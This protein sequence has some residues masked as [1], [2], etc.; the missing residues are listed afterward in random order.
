MKEWLRFLIPLLAT[1]AL[2]TGI[3]SFLVSKTSQSWFERDVALRS[4]LAVNS[5]RAS[6][7]RAWNLHDSG[8]LR[9]QLEEITRDTR[10]AGAGVCAPGGSVAAMA[11]HSG[12]GI[13]C[14]R[15]LALRPA[16]NDQ[17][18]HGAYPG[19]ENEHFSAVPV[20][21]GGIEVCVVVIIHDMTYAERRAALT[22]QFTFFAL[23]ALAITSSA[24]TILFLR[25]VRR[26]WDTQIRR[27]LRGEGARPEFQ[28]LRHD[29]QELARQLSAEFESSEHWNAERLRSV[30]HR[31]LH[32][33]QIIVLANREP[34]I[35]ERR[36]DGEIELVHPASGVVTALEPVMRACSGVWIAHGAGSADREMSDKNGRLQVPPGE[37]LYSLRRVWL[38]QEEERG[39]YYGFA[40]E[41]LWP[42]CHLAHARPMFRATDFRHYSRINARFAAAA[43]QEGKVRDPI[44]W[45]QDYHF[46]LAP[47]LV[48][49]KLPAATIL[50]FWH[51][52]WPNAER[53]GICPWHKELIAGLLGS[54]ILGFHTQLHCNNFLSAIDRFLETR[55]DR[56]RQSV[57][58]Q[59]H[60]TIVRPYP[61]S[62]EWPN[63]WAVA[64]PAVSECRHALITECDLKQDAVIGLGVDRLDYT[65]G[66]AERFLA[67]ERALERFPELR[68]RFSFVQLAAPSRTEIERYRELSSQIEQIVERINAR[69]GRGTYRPI[70]YHRAHH[71]PPKVF[72]FYRACDFCY[73][74]SLHDGMNLVA[75]EFVAARDDERGVLILSNFAG[76]SRELSSALIVNPYD[77][78]EASSAFATAV[79]MSSEEQ[80]ERMRAMRQTVAKFNVYRWA[81]RMMMDTAG[82]RQHTRLLSRYG[83]RD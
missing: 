75:K 45:I 4:E 12:L 2:L 63:S 28:P 48:R 13:D 6:V 82:L 40:N 15:V 47:Q 35:H 36:S 19:T 74:S 66:I 69:F 29:V 33:E 5:A 3:T 59:G 9:K 34:Y 56:E 51:I 52:P 76:A 41:G 23:G 58:Y 57:F 38:S 14:A 22:R 10:I 83:D 53:I 30:L 43:A 73:V 18:W 61:I 27:L 17:S 62:V 1:I 65:K 72:Q 80:Q 8:A 39:Y 25:Y 50:T 24:I 55:I 64:A 78:E 49:K 44:V 46:A 16:P 42:L 60:E 67:V 79:T 32:G 21:E 11:G 71:E 7:L 20:H 26:S 54:D 81:G 77:L 31:H 37:N 68:G 70:V